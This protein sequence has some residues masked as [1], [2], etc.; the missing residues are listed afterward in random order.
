M[1][2]DDPDEEL[3]DYLM[4][5]AGMCVSAGGPPWR[6][7]PPPGA[8]G[9]RD[10]PPELAEVITLRLTDV[11][12]ADRPGLIERLRAMVREAAVTPPS[13]SAG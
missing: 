2:R 4:E 5:E 8:D 10:F 1:T 13:A 11:A 12:P 6:E 7:W 9:G 3:I